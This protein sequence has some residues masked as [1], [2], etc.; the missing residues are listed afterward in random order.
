MPGGHFDF[1]CFR[2]SEFADDLK[3]EIGINDSLDTEYGF[4]YGKGYSPETI[5]RLNVAQQIIE[6]AGKLA[7]EIEWLYSNDIGE[8]TFQ[9]ATDKIFGGVA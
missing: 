8:E 7:K 4:T 5:S 2:I 9:T 1:N 6:T 3:S